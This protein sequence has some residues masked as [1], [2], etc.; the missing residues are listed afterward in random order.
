MTDTLKY[1]IMVYPKPIAGFTALPD[2]ASM[3][4]PV[5]KFIDESQD[6]TLWDWDLGD[7]TTS[8]DQFLI[9]T[10]ADTGTYVVTQ[11]AINKYGCRDTI[12]HNVR[13]NGE[14]T[15]FIPNAFT[16]DG[17]GIND[18]FIPKMFGVREFNMS[19]YDRFGD[20]IFTSVDTEVGWN[21]KVNGAG[22][23]VKDDVYIYKIYIRDLLNNPHT[24]KGRV[25]VLKKSD[26]E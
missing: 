7:H 2:Q 21:G 15:I 3:Y 4:E 19:I 12:Q 11:V 17:N 22:E 16:P 8:V 24:Y 14:P 10:Y 13:I 20:L 1:P 23:T 9:H 25:T 18:T 26:K 5:I 6:A